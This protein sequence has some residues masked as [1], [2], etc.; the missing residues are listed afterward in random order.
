MLIDSAPYVKAAERL[1]ILTPPAPGEY[2]QVN[3]FV[4]GWG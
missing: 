2:N 3:E 1:G 4:Q